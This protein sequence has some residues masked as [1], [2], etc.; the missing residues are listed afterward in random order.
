MGSSPPGHVLLRPHKEMITPQSA[1]YT[2]KVIQRMVKTTVE[3][4][5]APGRRNL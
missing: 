4:I 1:I 3:S 5:K 2:R